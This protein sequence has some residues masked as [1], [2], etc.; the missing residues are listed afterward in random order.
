MKWTDFEPTVK[1]GEIVYICDYR[2][3]GKMIEKAIRHIEPKKVM[4]VSSEKVQ[5]KIY[6]SDWCFVELDKKGEP[7]YKKSIAPFDNTGYRSYTGVCLN[8]FDNMDDCIKF[9]NKTK[10]DLLKK[11][12]EEKKSI[13]NLYDSLIE[14]L[15]KE[16]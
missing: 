13:V 16:S 11:A 4:I 2:Y 6:Y 7:N 14:Y 5:K 8:I 15:N 1:G 10:K 3:N 9:F 12:K